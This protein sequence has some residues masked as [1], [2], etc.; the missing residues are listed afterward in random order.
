MIVCS[1]VISRN[2]K[3]MQDAKRSV[4]PHS[5]SHL[6]FYGAITHGHI[7][8]QL[9]HMQSKL[10]YIAKPCIKLLLESHSC[11]LLFDHCIIIK[12]T[13][14]AGFFWRI[15]TVPERLLALLAVEAI[16]PFNTI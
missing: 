9:C 5:V 12:I 7:V 15:R 14:L 13:E 3:Q 2:N 10:M 4:L 6:T 11:T 8:G 1:G 16:L